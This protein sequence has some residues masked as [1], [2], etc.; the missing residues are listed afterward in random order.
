MVVCALQGIV[1]FQLI[2]DIYVCVLVH[3]ILLLS[4]CRIYSNVLYFIP[5]VDNLCP[6]SLF[7]FLLSLARG[8][9]LFL[10]F[11]KKKLLSGWFFSVVFVL[12]ISVV[13]IL[14][15]SF[16]SFSSFVLTF[17][18]SQDVCW[19]LWLEHFLLFWYKH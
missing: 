6:F 12:L 16:P 19:D 10:I 1:P 14:F 3:F 2:C 8:L 11:S 15:Y 18:V 9:L 5:D 17:L 13:S 7:F 4:I